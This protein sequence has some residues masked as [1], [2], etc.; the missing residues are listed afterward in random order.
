MKVTFGTG[1]A[2]QD[3]HPKGKWLCV[4]AIQ[5]LVLTRICAGSS[6]SVKRVLLSWCGRTPLHHFLL[7]GFLQSVGIL[8]IPTETN[9]E[10]TE[11]NRIPSIYMTQVLI[12][13]SLKDMCEEECRLLHSW[14]HQLF[15]S[16]FPL[17]DTGAGQHV[18][19]LNIYVFW[20]C[21]PCS[22]TFNSACLKGCRLLSLRGSFHIDLVLEWCWG[23][24]GQFW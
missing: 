22:V 4:E 15:S 14:L 2:L 1:S 3:I 6:E 7:P 11:P 17:F 23:L 10:K 12:Y 24:L 18:C 16:P 8:E 20:G 19:W 9:I 5:I 13:T 21:L